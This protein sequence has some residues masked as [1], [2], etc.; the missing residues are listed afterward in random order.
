MGFDQNAGIR[1]YTFQGL[2]DGTRSSFTVGVDLA[3]LPRY[4]IRIQELPL[5][6][7]GVLE[8]RE[9]AEENRTYTFSEGDMRGYAN[10]CA[11]AR[12]AAA[13]KRASRKRPETN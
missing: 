2:Q 4:D 1:R 5:L 13:Q 11:T 7:R 9:E 12:E 10:N 6:C 3:L 8:R